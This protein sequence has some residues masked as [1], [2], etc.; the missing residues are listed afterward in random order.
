MKRLTGWEQ[1]W[2]YLSVICTF[3]G[4]FTLKVIIKKAFEVRD[5]TQTKRVN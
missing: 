1:F 4:A 5:E 2:Y 3:G